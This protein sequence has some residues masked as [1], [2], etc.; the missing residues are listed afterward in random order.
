M[1]HHHDHASPTRRS[2][3]L[4][5]AGLGALGA[6][7]L[8][9]GPP[10]LAAAHPAP[11][12]APTGSRLSFAPVPI[13]RKDEVTVP[14]GYTVRVLAPWGAPIGPRGPRWRPD[15]S[16]TA[17]AA[18]RQVGT[19]HGGVEYLPLGPGHDG[20]RRG[21]L[22]LTHATADPVLLHADGGRS[23][24]A[25]HAAK[26]MASLGVTVLRIELRDGRW[27]VLAD[28]LNRRLT[29][30]SPV[31]FS[32]P[33]DGH[34][35][36]DT[37]AEALGLLGGFA[38]AATPWGTFLNGEDTLAD[39]FGTDDRRWRPTPEQERYGLTADTPDY[40]W[41]AHHPRFDLAEA[42]RE[43][44]RFGW[45]VEVDPFAPN[46]APVKR[47]ALGRL[48]AR[49]AAVAESRGYAVV[50]LSDDAHLYKFVTARPWRDIRNATTSP[51]DEG[52][53]H[54]ARLDT[55]GTGAWI[56]LVH[57]REGLRTGFR[58]QAD[59]LLR[60][61]EAADAV[62]ATALRE[63][64]QPAVHP[65]TGTVYCPESAGPGGGRV[66]AWTEGSGDHGAAVMSWREFA[67]PEP[68]PGTDP[69]GTVFGAPGGVHC[70]VDGR[71]WITTDVPAVAE[72][73]R[74][75]RLGN[76]ALLCA[77]PETGEVRRFLTGPPGCAISGVSSTPDQGTLF[78]TVHGPGSAGEGDDGP[79]AQDPRA[80][81]N[82]PGFDPRGRPRSAVVVVSRR[83]G[84]RV[85]T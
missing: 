16:D 75:V 59:V 20:N 45:T 74:R 80:V 43:V 63:P 53:L 48:A 37:G 21:L 34:S 40:G 4:T 47:T 60:A 64:G 12:A 51:L 78:V 83:D 18:L 66:L 52:T 77:D 69:A 70:G 11:S 68:G 24:T 44:H 27:R 9:C 79:T 1:A 29:P 8:V 58:D 38:H 7:A 33:L 84:G 19:G 41:H 14:E 54:A 23:A 82:W 10:A 49:G 72:P 85:G 15:A 22:V 32:G 3:L 56:P 67:R 73:E 26:E 5:T 71:L 61:R 25:A 35:A 55:D 65:V 62:G 76:S 57:G 30:S 46:A 39:A 81:S 31:A 36:L 50:Y 28:G 2:A 13:A 17:A 6:S 42:P